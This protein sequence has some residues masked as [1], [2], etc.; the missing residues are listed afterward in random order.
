MSNMKAYRDAQISLFQSAVSEVVEKHSGN[1]ILSVNG[2][3]IPMRA[4]TEDP[5]LEAVA[6]YADAASSGAM[7]Q[8]AAPEMLSIIDEAKFCANMSIKIGEALGKALIRGD[9][10]RCGHVLPVS[11]ARSISWVDGVNT[12]E[13][14]PPA[15]R[16]TFSVRLVLDI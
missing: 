16:E 7:P 8:N 6:N 1:Q 10:P 4:T 9:H 5:M 12:G 13:D 14:A 3:T 2:A 15:C 11:D